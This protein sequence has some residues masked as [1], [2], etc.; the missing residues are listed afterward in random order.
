MCSP[1]GRVE[2]VNYRTSA[3]HRIA[4]Y[5]I[6]RDHRSIH[7]IRVIVRVYVVGHVCWTI[8]GVPTVAEVLVVFR[9]TCQSLKI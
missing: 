7:I 9:R 5:I 3:T 6:G 1:F 8:L 2:I 4:V